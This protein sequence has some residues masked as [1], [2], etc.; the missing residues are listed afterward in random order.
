M[1]KNDNLQGSLELL[2]LKIL[3]TR[4]RLHGYGILNAIQVL[5]EDILRVEEGSLYPALHRMEE[6]G[7]IKGQWVPQESGR[8][9]RGYELTQR[10]EEYL[11]SEEIRWTTVAGA[12]QR[13][14][15][16]A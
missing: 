2:V 9:L 1:A 13:I 10:G 4:P 12:V 3:S 15:K 8:R 6:T 11:K 7:L 16:F 14:L 5:S